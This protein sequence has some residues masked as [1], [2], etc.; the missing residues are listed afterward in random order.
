MPIVVT[1]AVGLLSAVGQYLG[2]VPNNALEFRHG[3][4]LW[5]EEL[6]LIK[7]WKVLLTTVFLDDELKQTR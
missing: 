1:T 7:M 6:D 2:N 3:Q 5:N 4:I